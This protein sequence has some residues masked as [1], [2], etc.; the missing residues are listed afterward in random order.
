MITRGPLALQ[1]TPSITR[2]PNTSTFSI[3]TFVNWLGRGSH[4]RLHT[5]SPNGSRYP[6]QTTQ[7]EAIRTV[8]GATWYV[9]P[10]ELSDDS[11]LWRFH[12]ATIPILPHLRLAVM[13]Y[14]SRHSRTIIVKVSPNGAY[15]SYRGS[16]SVPL[17]VSQYS[18]HLQERLVFGI[19]PR[20]YQTLTKTTSRHP[21]SISHPHVQL[22]CSKR[23]YNYFLASKDSLH[24][25]KI[26]ALRWR[27]LDTLTVSHCDTKPFAI[28]LTT[29]AALLRAS[30]LQHFHTVDSHLE[31]RH[32]QST[33]IKNIA[34]IYCSHVLRPPRR[35]A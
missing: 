17:P 15:V 27:L 30:P 21:S 12:I 13:P 1:G 9:Q 10:F 11:K 34:N 31:H 6:H 5:H 20:K 23:Q 28:I 18:Q 16:L 4:H 19:S 33:S 26:H 7:Q 3:I 32:H 24:G 29:F 2:G 22:R 8:Q 35:H 14:R 25:N